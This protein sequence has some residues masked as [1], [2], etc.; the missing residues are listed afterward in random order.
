MVQQRGGA[1]D[2]SISGDSDLDIDDDTVLDRLRYQASSNRLFFNM[3]P[4]NAGA[5]FGSGGVGENSEVYLATPYGNVSGVGI[6]NLT[7]NGVRYGS[8]TQTQEDILDQLDAGDL[9]NLVISGFATDLMPDFGSETIADQPYTQNTAIAAITLPE[10]TGGD[11][12]LAYS[13]STLP[14]GLAFNAT[15]RVLSEHTYGNRHNGDGVHRDR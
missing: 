10:A 5:I 15:T 7:L 11:G 9:V 4:A 8:L 1:S 12:T 13:L 14:P 3:T 6:L 2:G